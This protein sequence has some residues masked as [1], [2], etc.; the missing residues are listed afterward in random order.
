MT[1]LTILFLGVALASSLQGCV[2]PMQPSRSQ[3]PQ[4]NLLPDSEQRFQQLRERMVREQLENRDIRDVQI[5]SIMRKVPRHRFVPSSLADSAYDD[6]P[7]PLILGQTISQPYIVGYMTQALGC[8][9]GDRILEIGTGSGYQAAIL[10]ELV[11]EVY[12]IEI[13]PELAAGAKSTLDSLGYRNIT[14]RIGDGYLG[15]PEAAPFDRIIVT[16]APDRIPQPLIDQLKPGGAMVIPVG[17]ANQELVL[18]QKGEHGISRRTLIPVR[19]VPITGRAQGSRR[20]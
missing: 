1:G 6:T 11:A 2:S 19:F 5:L 18:L 20:D 14:I 13:L 3:D 9:S 15:W 10:A 12:T 4:A 16:A 8:R 17:S 7:L